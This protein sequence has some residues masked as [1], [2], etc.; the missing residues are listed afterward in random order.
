MQRRDA[1]SSEW[2]AD[3]QGDGPAAADAPAVRVDHDTTV[4]VLLPLPLGEAYDYRVPPSMAL[5]PGDFVAVPLGKRILAG[6]VWGKARGDVDPGKL[7]DVE[8]VLPAAEDEDEGALFDKA[9]CSSAANAGSAA[10][11]DCNLAP[12]LSHDFSLRGV[13]TA[14]VPENLGMGP[15]A[16]LVEC[17]NA[18]IGGARSIR[19]DD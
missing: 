17:G 14:S 3:R 2:P 8:R 4:A 1:P 15:S 7:R 6:V 16:S 13:G 18:H 10:R 11:N 5:A 19:L 9:P 12:K